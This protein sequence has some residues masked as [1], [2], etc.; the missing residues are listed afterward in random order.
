MK[1]DDER[2][3]R[4]WFLPHLYWRATKAMQPEEV[5]NLMREVER[6]A[7][8]QDFAALRKYPFIHIGE[9]CHRKTDAVVFGAVLQ[10]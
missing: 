10:D 2:N 4:I 5:D 7:E 1:V 3:Q 9:T 6:L 8:A